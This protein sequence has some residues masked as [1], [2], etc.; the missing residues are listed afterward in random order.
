MDPNQLIRNCN[1]K[2]LEE[3]SPFFGKWVAWSED[4]RDI[5]A[6]APDLEK[7]FLEI[8]RKG[9]TDYVLDHI[10]LPE[11]DFLGGGSI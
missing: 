6:S 8:D 3:L 5:L 1:Q 11:E 7:L 9:L 10:P 4:G 2:S